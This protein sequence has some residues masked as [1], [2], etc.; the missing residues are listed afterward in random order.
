MRFKPKYLWW[1]ILVIVGGLSFFGIVSLPKDWGSAEML[2]TSIDQWLFAHAAHPT[3]FA[4]VIAFVFGT[5]IAPEAFQLL[6]PHIFPKSPKPDMKINDAID[7]IVN[8]SSSQL[9]Q[10]SPPRSEEGRRLIETGVQHSDA[11]RLISEKLANG[12]FHAW[13]LREITSR[14]PNQ[15]ETPR[16]PIPTNYWDVMALHPMTCFHDTERAAQTIKSPGPIGH[17]SYAGLMLCRDEVIRSFRK[18]NIARRAWAI[19]RKQPRIVYNR[20]PGS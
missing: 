12:E 19:V 1:A 11:L 3:L 18:K 2:L 5:V 8:D 17:L 14:I 16:K 4:L 13:G 15:F 6:K 10:P 20:R 9:K 7:Y